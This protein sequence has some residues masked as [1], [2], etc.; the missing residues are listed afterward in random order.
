M[1]SHTEM[2]VQLKTR[3]SMRCSTSTGKCWGK[4]IG[5]VDAL[6]AQRPVHERHAP[7][8]SETQSL[9]AS[10]CNE[11]GYPTNLVARLLYGCGL[12]VT[13]PLNLRIKDIDL[14]AALSASEVPKEAKTG[15]CLCRPASF[16]N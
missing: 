2:P 12:R 9:V 16:P 11:G 15:L 4:A 1:K 7:T 8:V 6:R 13:E 10:V 3:L 14:E 5:N